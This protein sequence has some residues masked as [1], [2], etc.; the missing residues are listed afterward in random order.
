MGQG[1]LPGNGKKGR[2]IGM[3]GWGRQEGWISLMGEQVQ[4]EGVWERLRKIKETWKRIREEKTRERREMGTS[5]ST[6]GY[7]RKG[8]VEGRGKVSEEIRSIWKT[9]GL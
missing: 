5:R 3:Q 9:G 1:R 7:R 2:N 8:A 6:C 4:G